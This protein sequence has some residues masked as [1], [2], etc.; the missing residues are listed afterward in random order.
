MASTMA[1]VGAATPVIGP[2]QTFTSV[3]ETISTRA[4]EGRTPRWWYVGFA[5]SCG[6]LVLFVIACV[7]TFAAG[8][9]IWGINIPVAWGLALANYVWWIGIASGGTFISSLFYLV[10]ADW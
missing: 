5:I 2:E 3:S 8:V 1:D 10:G 4:L 6:F 7:W 9:G